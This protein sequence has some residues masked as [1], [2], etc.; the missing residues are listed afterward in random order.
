MRTATID[1]VSQRPA[2]LMKQ[3]FLL[4]VYNNLHVIDGKLVIDIDYLYKLG[5]EAIEEL[6]KIGIEI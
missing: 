6:Q 2:T 4:D 1:N 5:P 3:N